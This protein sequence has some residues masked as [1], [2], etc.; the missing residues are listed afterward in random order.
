MAQR[1]AV[2]SL[3]TTRTAA[4]TVSIA[5]IAILFMPFSSYAVSAQPVSSPFRYSFNA[6]GTLME[7]GSMGESS[8][9]YF[10]L[11]SGGKFIIKG[12][13]GMTVQDTLAANDATRLLYAA[14]NSLDTG[15]GYS[16]QNL[17]RLLTR[18]TWGNSQASV[19]FKIVE[20]NLTNTPNRDGYSGILLMGR[21]KDGDNLYYAGIR[22]DGEAVIK[23]K[24]GGTYHTL[25]EK[26][27]FGDQDDYDRWQ[28]PNLIPQ[29]AWMGLRAKYENLADGSVR[30][31]LYLDK[32][33]SGNYTQI[34]S[35]IDSGTGGAPFTNKGYAGI[36]TDYM[37]VQFEDFDLRNL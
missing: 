6:N 29:N 34:L 27:V 9:P 18:S 36:R 8:S 17:L 37:D 3:D 24:I 7:T 1:E 20:T 16:P 35:V 30:I 15:N 14:S 28:N 4:L 33:N 21:Y 5:A 31:Q 12:G 13:V 10:W 25:G 11:N 26:Q 32:N 2:A 19:K 23:K 22:Q